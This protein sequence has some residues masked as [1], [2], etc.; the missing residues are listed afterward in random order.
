MR[1]LVVKTG[2]RHDASPEAL[3][4]RSWGLGTRNSQNNPGTR[5]EEH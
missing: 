3:A 1:D 4:L 2:A 5:S